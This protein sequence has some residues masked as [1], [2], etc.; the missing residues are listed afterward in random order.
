MSTINRRNLVAGGA[1]L[2]VAPQGT[3]S[4][5]LTQGLTKL[6]IA[7]VNAA[8]DAPFWIAHKKGFYRD[9]G[10]DVEFMI[11][12]SAAR[13]IAALASGE[14]DVGNGA[15]SAALYNAVGRGIGIKMVADK[16]KTLTGRG[17][18]KLIVRRDLIDT[19]RYKTLADLKGSRLAT[20]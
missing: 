14:L 1:A 6:T 7:H 16:T 11:F 10:L 15:P 19:G 13:M 5:A 17:T 3:L 12:P 18:Q 2:T 20:L 9:A 4:P 8:T